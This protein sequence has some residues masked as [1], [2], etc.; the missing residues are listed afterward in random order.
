M[1]LGTAGVDYFI[2]RAYNMGLRRTTDAM[3]YAC[4]VLSYVLLTS[5]FGTYIAGVAIFFIGVI[6]TASLDFIIEEYIDR[7]AKEHNMTRLLINSYES[8][9]PTKDDLPIVV[10]MGGWAPTLMAFSML[11]MGVLLIMLSALGCFVVSRMRVTL[12]LFLLFVLVFMLIVQCVFLYSFLNMESSLHKFARSQLTNRLLREYEIGARTSNTFTVVLNAVML[13]AHCCGIN[14]PSD[15]KAINMTFVYSLDKHTHSLQLT[16][17]PACCKE[18]FIERGFRQTL[19]CAHSRDL[20]NINSQ[21][22]YSIV[23]QLL[24][25]KLSRV[26]ALNIIVATLLWEFLQTFITLLLIFQPKPEELSAMKQALAAAR[27][28]KVGHPSLHKIKKW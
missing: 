25:N 21:D 28:Y 2:E 1:R 24:S 19:T 20:S 10:E 13:L 5:M 9:V 7:M 17:P 4:N 12:L 8:V 27:E 22:C 6:L 18:S 11:L 16:V 26:G 3:V 15:F 23:F 14:G